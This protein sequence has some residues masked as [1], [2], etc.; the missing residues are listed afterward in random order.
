MHL[1]HTFSEEQVSQYDEQG[2]QE[3]PSK[4]NPVG[5]GVFRMHFPLIKS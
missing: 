4:N 5:H 3:S 2:L 1:S